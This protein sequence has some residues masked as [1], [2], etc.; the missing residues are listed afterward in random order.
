MITE[1]QADQIINHLARISEG[2]R[3][4]TTKLDRMLDHTSVYAEAMQ[5]RMDNLDQTIEEIRDG[6]G[7]LVSASGT[8]GGDA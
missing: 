3:D 7:Q 6:I 1:Q 5:N 4:L 8:E 2:V